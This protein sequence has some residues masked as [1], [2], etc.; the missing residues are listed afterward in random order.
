MIGRNGYRGQTPELP[1]IEQGWTKMIGKID[2]GM[3]LAAGMGLL[4]G[5]TDNQGAN[6][7]T[8]ALLGAAA[9]QAVGQGR[10]RTARFTIFRCM[11]S[12]CRKMTPATMLNSIR[13]T[14]KEPTPTGFATPLT[15]VAKGWCPATGGRSARVRRYSQTGKSLRWAVIGVFFGGAAQAQDAADL[16]QELANPLA[17][18]VSV[19]FQLNSDG[20][21]GPDDAGS[22][23]TLNLQPVIP[24]A[25]DNGANIITRTIIPY[26][27]QEDVIPGTS[28]SGFG[29]V[30]VSAWYSRTTE[31]NLTWG[32]GP[33][34]RVP[35]FSDVSSET[36]AAGVTGIAL[37]QTGPWTVGALA[38]HL[39]HLESDPE[40]PVNASFFQP[41]VAYSTETAWTYSLQS[42]TTYDWEAE[43]WAVPV[44]AS[45]SKLA[46]IG[47]RP[48]N[49]Q[50]GVGYWLESPDGGPEGWRY[51]LQVQF[52]FSKG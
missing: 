8:C 45:V 40:T 32:V 37:R 42:E 48:I 18:I 12:H 25:L 7:A 24:F 46:V 33:V 27:W 50:G 41:F 23:T 35:T 30:L 22:R 2:F 49:F 3:M 28:Q 51:R 20:N 1:R 4:T 21:L 9:G 16:A 52:V 34:V 10:G 5:R 11:A 31:A 47:G 43:A 6:A 36:W 19:P 29:D 38:N 13:A 17:A 26:I 15:P 39:W 14:A 44:N